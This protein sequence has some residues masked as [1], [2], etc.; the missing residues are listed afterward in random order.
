MRRSKL[1]AAVLAIYFRLKCAFV[2]YNS[3]FKSDVHIF[4]AVCQHHL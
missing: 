4:G 3:V 1:L 2:G